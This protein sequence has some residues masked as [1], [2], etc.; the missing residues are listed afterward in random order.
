VS[1]R[2]SGQYTDARWLNFEYVATE[3][4]DSNE[5][6]NVDLTYVSPH[7]NWTLSA[8]V[9]N[10]DDEAVYTGGGEQGFAPPLVYATIGA[11]RTYGAR[12]QYAF[13]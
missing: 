5:V 2:V 6:Y 12:L 11:P 4:A 10:L 7:G 13:E 8:F 3:R 9:H 1:A